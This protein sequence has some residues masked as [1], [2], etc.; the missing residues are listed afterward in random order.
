MN[1]L[2][3]S[4]SVWRTYQKSTSIIFRASQQCIQ[5]FKCDRPTCCLLAPGDLHLLLGTSSGNL[6]LYDIGSGIHGNQQFNVFNVW[7]FVKVIN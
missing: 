5:T 4:N 6:Q 3:H 2:K 1:H 7:W